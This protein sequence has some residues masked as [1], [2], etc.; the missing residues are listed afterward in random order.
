MPATSGACQF[1]QHGLAAILE[2]RQAVAPS[3]WSTYK[4]VAWR[5]LARHGRPPCVLNES[6]TMRFL[7]VFAMALLLAGCGGGD[8]NAMPD[9]GGSTAVSSG[10]TNPPPGG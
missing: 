6:G 4:R 7:P 8:N 3:G 9:T 1:A 5:V 10:R 2:R